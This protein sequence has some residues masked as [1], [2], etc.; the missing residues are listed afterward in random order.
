ML[1]GI[2]PALLEPSRLRDLDLRLLLEARRLRLLESCW[3]WLLEA[4]VLRLLLL[5]ELLRLLTWKAGRLRL[6]SALWEAGVLL[7]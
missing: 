4:R 3:L 5:L 7:L 1:E 2:L 6:Q